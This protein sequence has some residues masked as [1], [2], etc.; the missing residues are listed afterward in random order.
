MVRGYIKD[1]HCFSIQL[2]GGR[3]RETLKPSNLLFRARA[4]NSKAG[5]DDGGS[6]SSESGEGEGEG[7]GEGKSKGGGGE[8]K[9]QGEGEGDGEGAKMQAEELDETKSDII[10]PAL[11]PTLWRPNGPN[12]ASQFHSSKVKLQRHDQILAY[13]YN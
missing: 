1:K 2:P 10:A 13:F 5:G 12:R 7:E 11:L 9:G 3:G 6:E 8:G 4:V